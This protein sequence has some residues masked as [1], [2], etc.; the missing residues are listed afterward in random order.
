M[1]VSRRIGIGLVAT[2]C[3]LAS[4]AATPPM[5]RLAEAAGPAASN[6][7]DPASR[8]ATVSPAAA[9]NP[10]PA[11]SQAGPRHPRPAPRSFMKPATVT[12]DPSKPGHLTIGDAGL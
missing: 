9:S 1:A 7:F 11:S 3:A 10:A 5:G 4:P 2:L 6:Q 8:A 12:L